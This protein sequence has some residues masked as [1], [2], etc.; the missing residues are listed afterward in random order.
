LGIQ[1]KNGNSEEVEAECKQALDRLLKE[2]HSPASLDD[3][4]PAIQTNSV[5]QDLLGNWSSWTESYRERCWDTLCREMEKAAYATRPYCLRCGDCCRQGSP[6]LFVEDMPILRQGIIKRPDLFTLRP[7]EIGFSGITQD[8][9]LLTEERIKIK[10]KPGSRE[11]L[12]F[13]PET[14]VCSIYEGRPLQ[15]REME[16]WNP[17]NFQ[18]L[19]SHTFLSRKDLLNP[20]DPLIPIIES[21][22]GRCA[23]P[24]LQE[25]LSGIK[26]DMAAAQDKAL[27]ILFF[28]RHLREYLNQELGI[29]PENQIFLLGRPV[30]DLIH[31][32]GF[33]VEEDSGGRLKLAINDQASFENNKEGKRG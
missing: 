9:V 11:C 19:D 4:W 32:F 16:C 8:L 1:L 22:T 33:H 20:D 30:L 10:E 31:S 26:K 27:D 21:H 14:N 5:F 23:V 6:T 2:I 3:L 28:D 15:C 29:S 25:A 7:G 13:D 17:D 18:G 24:D 12:A